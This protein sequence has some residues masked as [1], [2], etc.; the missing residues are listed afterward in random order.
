MEK[1]IINP[2]CQPNEQGYFGEFGGAFIPEML[3]KNVDEL[4]THYLDVIQKPEFQQEFRQLLR[5]YVGR[6]SPLYYSKKLSTQFN[7]R[8]YLKRE[9]LNHTGA[10]KINNTLGQILL[11]KHLNKKRI[12]AET[13]AGQHGVAT[14]T[15]CALMGLPCTIY[16]GAVDIE[17]QM[18][19]VERMRLMG[20]E[21]IPAESRSK[22]LKDDTNEAMR[23]WINDPLETFYIIGSVVGP[24]PYPD[25]VTLFQSIISEEIKTQLQEKEQTAV[26]DY[27]IAC[28]GGGSN[29]IGAF[30][31]FIGNQHTKLIA[32]EAGG[33]GV[34]TGKTAASIA[35]G[36]KGILHGSKTYLMQTNDGQIIEPYSISAGLDY[37]GIGPVH[38]YLHDAKQIEVIA[39]D[40]QQAINAALDL[41]KNEGI[42]PALESAHAL[43]ALPMLNFENNPIVVINLSGRGDKDMLT[44]QKFIP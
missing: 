14:A 33:K 13:G 29:A 26:P 44:F 12:I 1:L 38:A 27:V 25:M 7:A 16:M 20:A 15:A 35:G 43:A 18:P 2:N 4:K 11:A 41:A 36:T 39:V 32:V 5:D 31:H 19:N 22:T 34:S 28:V 40:D 10:H 8:V 30:Y 23:A 21:I 17:R 6:P 37:P 3:Y 24:H 9:D 42:I